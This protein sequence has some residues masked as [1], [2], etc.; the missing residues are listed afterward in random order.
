MQPDSPIANYVLYYTDE[1]GASI[2]LIEKVDGKI[3]HMGPDEMI[4]R[5]T[6]PPPAGDVDMLLGKKIF[7][8][9]KE[10]IGYEGGV[11]IDDAYIAKAEPWIR[12]HLEAYRRNP[13][14]TLR[15]A[16]DEHS[17]KLN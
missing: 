13:P 1:K 2:K 14:I 12:P 5:I 6:R 10:I 17:R 16:L 11:V 7:N 9:K 8:D 4:E 15:E 3:V